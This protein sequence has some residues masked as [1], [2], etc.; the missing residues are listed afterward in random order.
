[1][2]LAPVPQRATEHRGR[3]ALDDDVPLEGEPGRGARDVIG[4]AGVE[5]V[6]GDG[7]LHD[8]AMRVARVAVRTS[9]GAADVRV[10]GPEAHL[11]D[12]GPVE[13]A[14][15]DGIVV[16][17]VLLRIEDGERAG[18]EE[19]GEESG[20]SHRLH[21]VGP[22]KSGGGIYRTETESA[23]GVP[24]AGSVRRIATYEKPRRISLMQ[25]G[26]TCFEG[27]YSASRK[28]EIEQQPVPQRVHR[29][30]SA[31]PASSFAIDSTSGLN[32]QSTCPGGST[33]RPIES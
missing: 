18:A 11:R 10:D 24:P 3:V 5:R 27:R 6:R 22:A 23:R 15:R 20:L 8:V 26:F 9:E 7:A 4:G 14:P 21:G 25:R 1:M 30:S 29:P 31:S 33:T 17:D 19:V 28:P 2:L 32:H 12:L 13:D 16:R